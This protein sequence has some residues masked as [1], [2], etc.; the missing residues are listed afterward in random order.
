M[1]E[2][3]TTEPGRVVNKGFDEFLMSSQPSDF[4]WVESKVIFLY[5]IRKLSV[6]GRLLL[7]TVP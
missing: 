4:E 5:S 3:N 6:A 7:E 1:F 2:V